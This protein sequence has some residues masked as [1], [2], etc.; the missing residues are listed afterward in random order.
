[1]KINGEVFFWPAASPLDVLLV[2]VAELCIPYHPHQYLWGPTQIAAGDIC[3]DIGACEG[4]FSAKASALGARV[5]CVEPSK[6][7]ASVIEKLF[8]ERG[9]DRPVI[10]PV[11]LG[12]RRECFSFFDD[13]QNP[14]G[15]RSA[16][17]GAYSVE[18]LTLDEL[19]ER[20]ALERLDFIKCDAEGS[21]VE[22]LKSGERSLRRFRP[23]IA[24]T[25]YHGDNDY[26]DLHKYLRGLGYRVRGKGFL[27]CGRKLRVNMLHAS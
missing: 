27:R 10:V 6:R 20:L 9:L 13:I 2:L 11:L 26:S 5:I 21:D 15:S 18:M 7:M 1:M 19:V 12:P 8:R 24:V 17:E 22:I 16:G 4:G 25:T 14:G 23:R 3:L